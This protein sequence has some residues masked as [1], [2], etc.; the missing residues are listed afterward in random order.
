VRERRT[1][2]PRDRYPSQGGYENAR[3][4]AGG[5]KAWREASLPVEKSA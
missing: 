1:R 4:L 5:L 2:H 3:A